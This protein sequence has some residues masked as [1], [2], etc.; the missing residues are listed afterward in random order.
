[1]DQNDVLMASSETAPRDV[2]LNAEGGGGG[3]GCGAA[4]IFSHAAV[5]HWEGTWSTPRGTVPATATFASVEDPYPNVYPLR[6]DIEI[7]DMPVIDWHAF[8]VGWF[9]VDG[10]LRAT[11]TDNPKVTEENA[12]F[13]FHK[14]GDGSC[15]P[16]DSG[17]DASA[18]G[19]ADGGADASVAEN[20]DGGD[21][22]GSDSG[23]DGG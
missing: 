20:P 2:V 1:M 11:E 7:G 23:D 13:V 14:V 6:F 5:A 17:V 21:D 19:A 4:T 9:R 12:E 18:D 10:S 8:E 22:G 3:N 16:L 15:R